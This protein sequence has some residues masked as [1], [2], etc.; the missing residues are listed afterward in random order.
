NSISFQNDAEFAFR[1][2]AR[3]RLQ[4]K[5]QDLNQ[6]IYK[7]MKLRDGAENLL[8]ALRQAK[9]TN[10]RRIKKAAKMELSNASMQLDR[11]REELEGINSAFDVYQFDE[12]M[13]KQIP[14]VSL[15]LRETTEVN[16]KVPFMDFIKSH[17]YKDPNDFESELE[18]YQEMRKGISNPSRD[19]KGC[20][21]LYQ[22]FNQLYFIEKKFFSKKGSM[23][24]YFQWY[25]A[26]TGLP[27]V[28]RSVAF[29]KASLLFNIASLWSQIGTKQDR[30]TEEGV[31]MAFTSFQKAAGVFGYTRDNFVNSPSV[32][33]TQ[34]TLEALMELMLVQAQACLW[35]GKIHT[36][37]I[38]D[39]FEDYI[40]A[41][42]ECAEICQGYSKVF[43]L[44]NTGICMDAIPVAWRNMVKIMYLY[45]KAL[46]HYYTAV[47]LLQCPTSPQNGESLLC[48]VIP[49]LYVPQASSGNV[50]NKQAKAHLHTALRNHEEAGRAKQVCSYCRKMVS[51]QKILSESRNRS[52]RQLISMEEEDDFDDPM[53]PSPVK[54]YV[55]Q[56]AQP[57]LPDFSDTAAEDL[58]HRLGPVHVFNADSNLSSSRTI[59]IRRKNGSFGFSVIGSAPVIVQ[60]AEEH[61]AAWDAGLQVGD[62]I[63]GVDSIDVKW[64]QHSDVVGII[65]DQSDS[66]TLE[67]KTPHS[68]RE[69]AIH[70]N[71]KV[72]KSDSSLSTNDKLSISS[73]GSTSSSLNP[74]I[75]DG[76]SNDSEGSNPIKRRKP[77]F[78]YSSDPFVR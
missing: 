28:Q 55:Q 32:D 30:S 64:K 27:K 13:E 69:I 9:A 3:W 16:F 17:Y 71:L 21:K 59:T 39:N 62:I 26:L 45:Y 18:E 37:E 20:Q 57:I 68:L 52:M 44:M 48:D 70:C 61:G 56:K 31:N 73:D 75:S 78:R 22:Y 46:S 8:K 66:V 5:R 24:V 25:D 6:Q 35:E 47:G 38:Q 14:M 53:S 19:K 40:K 72:I 60:C 2:S 34:D 50:I 76:G 63:I 51:L 58:F 41:G 36:Q 7:Q 1:R 29:E 77:V 15:G 65:R 42:Q 54:A 11:L 49:S 43:L 67:I 4:S 10:D 12:S 33:M 74:S 23:P